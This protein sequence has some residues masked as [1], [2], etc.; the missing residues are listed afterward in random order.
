MGCCDQLTALEASDLPAL[1]ASTTRR[2]RR[3]WACL[4]A[5]AQLQ[6]HPPGPSRTPHLCDPACCLLPACL[7]QKLTVRS[8]SAYGKALAQ[9]SLSGLPSLTCVQASP[10]ALALLPALPGVTRLELA[11]DPTELMPAHVDALA[12]LPHL[13]C[14]EHWTLFSGEKEGAAPVLDQLRQRLPHLAIKA[15]LRSALSAA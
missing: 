9:L 6:P 13:A 11:S 8:Y 4:P 2:G 10:E 3:A 15:E 12:R 14:L 5:L 1:Q 7:L